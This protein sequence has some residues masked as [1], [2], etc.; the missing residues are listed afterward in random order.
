M[1]RAEIRG[2]QFVLHQKTWPIEK[3]KLA[4]VKRWT[5]RVDRVRVRITHDS[6]VEKR[7][8]VSVKRAIQ[9]WKRDIWDK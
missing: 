5:G 7:T 1:K 6:R 3:Q 8:R 9:E 2:N 4:V